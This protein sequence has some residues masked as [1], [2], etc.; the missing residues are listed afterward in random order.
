[1][2]DLKSPAAQS[3]QYAAFAAGSC[4]HVDCTCVIVAV[5]ILRQRVQL[6]L[7]SRGVCKGLLF[8]CVRFYHVGCHAANQLVVQ[9]MQSW[10]GDQTRMSMRTVDF[11]PSGHMVLRD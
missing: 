10:S 4:Q 3:N 5:A 2:Y 9:T 6:R 1:M 11:G 7:S 8:Q